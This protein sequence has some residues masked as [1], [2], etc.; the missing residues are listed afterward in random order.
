MNVYKVNDYDWVVAKTFEEAKEWYLKETGV[1]D[2]ECWL[3]EE[4]SLDEMMW[5]EW[6]ELPEE[7]QHY[8]QEIKNGMVRRP[9]KW[10]M[11]HIYKNKET[12][13]LI[14]STEY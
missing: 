11:K 7:E 2:D 13:Y 3:E 5:I 6:T 12:P 9:F 10:V 8:A 1:R 4:C 14:A